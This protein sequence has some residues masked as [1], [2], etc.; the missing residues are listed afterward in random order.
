MEA[1]IVLVMRVVDA[2]VV[3]LRSEL[4]PTEVKT[5]VMTVTEGAA[6]LLPPAEVLLPVDED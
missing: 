4:I 5:E 3:R 6:V 2:I 1:A